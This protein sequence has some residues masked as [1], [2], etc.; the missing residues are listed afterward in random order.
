MHDMQIASEKT[1]GGPHEQACQSALENAV[2]YKHL[3]FYDC[4]VSPF[5]ASP[6]PAQGS[7]D[8]RLSWV[9]PN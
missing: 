7:R 3:G 6:G 5:P 9:A 2:L 1:M 8:G 4:V